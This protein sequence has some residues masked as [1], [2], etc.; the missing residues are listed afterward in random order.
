[1]PCYTPEGK[2]PRK[3]G[4]KEEICAEV[5]FGGAVAEAETDCVGHGVEVF[6]GVEVEYPF[7]ILGEG[8]M[9]FFG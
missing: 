8:V 5:E 3:P 1:V 4:R 9:N 6:G 7:G 2:K